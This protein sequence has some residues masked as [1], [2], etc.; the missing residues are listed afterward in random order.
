MFLKIFFVFRSN[1]GA[2]NSSV[3]HVSSP[4]TNQQQ[5]PSVL[6]STNKTIL[7]SA[8]SSASVLST[9]APPHFTYPLTTTSTTTLPVLQYS[10]IVSQNT[11]PSTS[12]TT[13]SSNTI[14]S[15]P[16]QHVLS[17]QTKQPLKDT[18]TT[19]S[20]TNDS[21]LPII[22]TTSTLPISSVTT[23]VTNSTNS[24]HL[25]SLLSTTNDRT[26]N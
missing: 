15:K 17:P 7:P 3:T 5:S 10:A 11:V 6:S 4:K 12:T 24:S 18:T 23:T 19:I 20:N 25:P 1:S 8:P 13:T 9:S 26:G 21:I 22:T 2:H 16:Q 14:V